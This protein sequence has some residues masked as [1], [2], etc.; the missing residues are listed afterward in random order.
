MTRAK[1]ETA[2]ANFKIGGTNVF[3]IEARGKHLIAVFVESTDDHLI[4]IA[5]GALEIPYQR[6]PMSVAFFGEPTQYARPE[7]VRL[8]QLIARIEARHVRMRIRIRTRGITDERSAI[9]VW[10]GEH[11]RHAE[12]F[13]APNTIIP[14]AAHHTLDRRRRGR[15]KALIERRRRGRKTIVIL[16]KHAAHRA[17][18]IGIRTRRDGFVRAR[19]ITRRFTALHRVGR[20]RIVVVAAHLATAAARRAARIPIA[21]SGTSHDENPEYKHPHKNMPGA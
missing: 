18:P 20:A 6:A 13:T 15:D 1:L 12:R 14:I 10:H 8:D 2:F 9:R 19:D 7:I 5:I 3:V 4:L 17:T 16:R 21:T 11:R